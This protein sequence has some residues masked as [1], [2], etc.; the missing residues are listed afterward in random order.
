MGRMYDRVEQRL[1]RMHNTYV[2]M[3]K[4]GLRDSIL[5]LDPT[6]CYI[7]VTKTKKVVGYYDVVPLVER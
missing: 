1:C 5:V 2:H 4:Q 3:C 6:F 7:T